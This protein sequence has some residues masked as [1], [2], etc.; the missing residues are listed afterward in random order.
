MDR[1]F[2]SKDFSKQKGYFLLIFGKCGYFSLILKFFTN[3][4]QFLFVV[5]EQLFRFETLVKYVDALTSRRVD[6]TACCC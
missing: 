3:T 5:S 4:V 1:K 6:A 2:I